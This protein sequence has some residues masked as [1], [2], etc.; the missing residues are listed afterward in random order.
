MKKSFIALIIVI[1]V[2]A[3]F[4]FENM[5]SLFKELEKNEVASIIAA[6][7]MQAELHVLKTRLR[8]LPP[9]PSG[10]F[11][12]VLP[13][14]GAPDSRQIVNS[15]KNQVLLLKK[16]LNADSSLLF[17]KTVRSVQLD[18]FRS[19]IKTL[20]GLTAFLGIFIIACGIY[21]VILLRKKGQ[22]KNAETI[23]PF[24]DY[25]LE[26]KKSELELKDLVAAQSKSSTKI[27][28]L[29]KSIISTINL[30]VIFADAAGKIEIFNPAA[31]KYFARSY[32]SAKNNSLA[33]VLRDHPELL[34]FISACQKKDSAEIESAGRVFYTDVVPVGTSGR[35]LVLRDVSSERK[36]ERIQRLNA[37]LMMLGEMAASLA[38]EIRN[39]LGVILGYSK[40]IRSEPGKTAKIAREIH[41]LSAM[42][43]SFL[44][45]ARP[46]QKAK[47]VKTALGPIIAASAAANNLALVLPEKDLQIESDPLLLNVIF[48]NLALNASQA[49]AG[50][51]QV[52]FGADENAVITI[53]DDGPGIAAAVRD[54][55]WLP[56]FSTR[57][58][59]TGMGLATV[60]K[61]VSALNGDIQLVD[62]GKPGAKFRIVFYS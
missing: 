34:A 38:H 4:V 25:L 21:L 8:S 57:D 46:V 37:N 44:Q 16:Q 35:L 15:D 36:R 2:I 30:A 53:R 7:D 42:M 9:G 60:K 59:G 55:I 13:V 40:A 32:A 52:E 58:K 26:I 27:E 14:A 23:S 50:R 24:Q 6:S 41:F 20:A 51:L 12:Q 61:L 19:V 18:T 54:K 45:F 22:A 49:G 29:N 56:F 1:Q 62:D 11:D 10:Y 47:Q 43:E 3:L 39:S 5:Y 31:Q 17:K 28:A 48:S 33:E